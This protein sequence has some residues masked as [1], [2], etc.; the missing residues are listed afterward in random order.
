MHD[1]VH[2][3][4]LLAVDVIGVITVGAGAAQ[5]LSLPLGC[6]VVLCRARLARSCLP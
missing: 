1:E 4:T 6:I 3:R 5:G 2:Q